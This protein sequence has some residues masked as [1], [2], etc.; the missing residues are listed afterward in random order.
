M[1]GLATMAQA[2]TTFIEGDF[3]YHTTGNNTVAVD[4]CCLNGGVAVVPQTVAYEGT[5]YTVTAVGERAF[6]GK[7]LAVV[8]LPESVTEIGDEAF[9]GS[10][11]TYV[12]IP[13]GVTRIGNGAFLDCPALGRVELPEALQELGDGA[14]WQ[15]YSQYGGIYSIGDMKLPNLTSLG[16]SALR[17]V[18]CFTS[19]PLMDKLKSIGSYAF[20]ETRLTSASL[21]DT[22]QT[23][24]N[25][26]FCECFA[27]TTVTAPA[28]N[29][30]GSYAF[31]SS[32]IK[33]IDVSNCRGPI[34]FNAFNGC[35][36]LQSLPIPADN[37]YCYAQNG[38]RVI[39]ERETNE[40]LTVL[41]SATELK[42][43]YPA[44]GSVNILN[45]AT[46]P[47]LVKLELP[48]TWEASLIG[49][50]L[51]ALQELTMR[52]ATPVDMPNPQTEW[53]GREYDE[54][55]NVV[56]Q[57]WPALYI[58]DYA[59]EAYANHLMNT[60]WYDALYNRT[61]RTWG[62]QSID[63]PSSQ[64]Y[65]AETIPFYESED[66]SISIEDGFAFVNRADW[67]DILME[68]YPDSFPSL[69]AVS[70]I[71]R[72][73]AQFKSYRDFMYK[74]YMTPDKTRAYTWTNPIDTLVQCIDG[75]LR[76]SSAFDAND[77]V[78]WYLSQTFVPANDF[79]PHPNF[80]SSTTATPMTIDTDS[81][82]A[83]LKGVQYYS[84]ACN[85]TG[86]PEVWYALNMLPGIHYNIY[87]LTAPNTADADE[88]YPYKRSKI[89][90]QFGTA[91]SETNGSTCIMESDGLSCDT[92]LLYDGYT[93]PTDYY[94]YLHLTSAAKNADVN[95]YGYT[96]A[97]SLRGVL[98]VPQ[99]EI[100]VLPSDINATAITPAATI[101][102][103][104]DLDGRRRD[105]LRRGVNIVRYSDGTVRKVTV[106]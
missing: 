80:A 41:P 67:Q 100:A 19:F 56:S 89:R 49:L 78:N 31:Y 34:G 61:D 6:Y 90:C 16:S 69:D 88:T 39:V 106:K 65:M 40:P 53:L 105:G 104:Y 91:E 93:V 63:R 60:G 50:N 25:G 79:Y 4:S 74:R 10:L 1:L 73:V 22:M 66:G 55:G 27:L 83:E 82:G 33:N 95:K 44:K 64:L 37:P 14:L 29:A 11:V 28:L 86:S 17:R 101:T 92:L 3:K 30:I 99:E 20:A 96:H 12:N 98:L 81:L 5:T 72:K 38:W 62:F 23:I 59:K 71:S 85:E 97:M 68:A 2:Q 102:D 84:I 75:T 46:Y 70:S 36:N 21:P 47:N 48:Y 32:S 58:F 76:I 77:Y 45:N 9:Y 8:G 51:P 43:K 18:K 15:H 26:L 42:V 52:S 103:V 7:A 13:K 87:L 94:N 54:E 24:P 57:A 35:S